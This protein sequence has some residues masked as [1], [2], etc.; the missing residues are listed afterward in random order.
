MSDLSWLPKT[1]LTDLIDVKSIDIQ[2]D[3]TKSDISCGQRLTGSHPGSVVPC[4]KPKAT[5]TQKKFK[6][7]LSEK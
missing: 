1:I 7:I 6:K 3:R 2:H 5:S 4:G